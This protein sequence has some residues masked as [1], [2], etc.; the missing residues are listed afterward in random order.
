MLDKLTK[1]IIKRFESLNLSK[2]VIHV[3]SFSGGKTSA[4]LVFVMEILRKHLGLNVKYL[5]MDTGA[6]HPKTYDFIRDVV[7]HFG[8]DLVCLRLKAT[9]KL[10]MANSYVE[11]EL[12]ELKTDLVGWNEMIVKYSTPYMSQEAFCTRAMKTDLFEWYCNEHFG[13]KNYRCWLGMRADEPTRMKPEG[14]RVSKKREK[15]YEGIS[16]L[17][18]ISDFGKEDINDHWDEMPFNLMIK[19][20]LGNCMWCIKKSELRLAL[21]ER[22]E[23]EFYQEFISAVNGSG[24]RVIEDRETPAQYMYRGGKKLE[25][26]IAVF[27]SSTTEELRERVRYS[28][29]GQCESSCDILND[30]DDVELPEVD[31][32]HFVNK[33]S[34]DESEKD[35]WQTPEA[36]FN[37]LTQEFDF[38]L[39]VCASKENAL[40]EFFFSEKNSALDHRWLDVD[41]NAFKSAFINP[42]YSQTALFLERSANQAIRHNITVVALVNANTD[43]QWF[44]EAVKTANEVRLLTGRIGFI[45]ASGGKSNGNTKGQCLIIWRGNCQTPCQITMVDRKTLEQA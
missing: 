10:G 45:K 34:T 9:E 41:G 13:K 36:I 44:A 1:E 38:E 11:L 18:D 21:A 24:V 37:C 42:P 8:I 17:A 32:S 43:T 33:T 23:P 16:Y 12:H 27:A 19:D 35:L 4:F 3:V 29:S 22:D 2:D 20:H 28:K 26:V 6:E 40:C 39:D 14:E 31:N 15:W 30:D 7:N 25:Q 5:F